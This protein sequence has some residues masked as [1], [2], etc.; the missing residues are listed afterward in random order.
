MN[1]SENLRLHDGIRGHVIIRDK[2]NNIL[3]DKDNMILQAGKEFIISKLLSTL[4]GSKSITGFNNLS[5]INGYE[6]SGLEFYYNAA[7]VAY[8]N[9]VS[10]IPADTGTRTTDTRAIK[11]ANTDLTY[12]LETD[13]NNNFSLKISTIIS[14]D[15]DGVD[16]ITKINS[17]SV[18][19]ENSGT[20]KLFSRVRFDDIILYSDSSFHLDYYIYF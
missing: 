3:V 9:S 4:N 20:K 12:T 1:T 10:L 7:E 8:N 2:E 17:C 6:I 15:N 16:S 5:S 13:T 19:L 14:F 11:K 18:L